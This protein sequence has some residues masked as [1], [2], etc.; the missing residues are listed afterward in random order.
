[1]QFDRIIS[2]RQPPGLRRMQ[3]PVTRITPRADNRSR[4]LPKRNRVAV[5]QHRADRGCGVP[6]PRDTT[7]P[8]DQASRSGGKHAPMIRNR[9]TES[10]LGSP[11]SHEI[12]RP[13]T[14]FD[15][16]DVVELTGAVELTA[17]ILRILRMKPEGA[18]LRRDDLVSNVDP[19][20]RIECGRELLLPMG[21]CL[22]SMINVDRFAEDRQAFARQVHEVES[23]AFPRGPSQSFGRDARAV[24]G[25]D[26]RA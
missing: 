18:Q 7:A 11:V 1:M 24:T 20:L 19:L 14:A 6:G 26:D 13:G 23:N 8:F 22:T 15:H 5:I 4:A 3:E 9:V 2:E 16:K 17:K 21:K 25:Q 12:G 10:T